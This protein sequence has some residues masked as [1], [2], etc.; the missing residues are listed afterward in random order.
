MGSNLQKKPCLSAKTAMKVT[1]VDWALKSFLCLGVLSFFF[2]YFPGSPSVLPSIKGHFFY[3]ASMSWVCV[4]HHTNRTYNSLLAIS[5][6]Q[7]SPVFCLKPLLGV[8]E[9]CLESLPCWKTYDLWLRSSFQTMGPTL[10]TS[11]IS[12]SL[13]QEWGP[14]GSL[15]TASHFIQMT[16]T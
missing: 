1:W 2:F 12:V 14:P 6:L 9:V 11:T 10:W 8:F 5:E 3:P 15:N 16:H 13:C 7:K 4:C